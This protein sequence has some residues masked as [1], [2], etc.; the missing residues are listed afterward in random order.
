[1]THSAGS[2]TDVSTPEQETA[3]GPAQPLESEP[4]VA[5]S[6]G[7][8]SFPRTRS[9]SARLETMTD[10]SKEDENPPGDQRS[11]SEQDEALSEGASSY[12][13]DPQFSGPPNLQDLVRLGLEYCL[14][15]PHDR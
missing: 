1:M 6:L 14:P 7:N 8:P 4:G 5:G 9:T 15:A 13:E 10:E 11:L 3:V 12:E 2:S